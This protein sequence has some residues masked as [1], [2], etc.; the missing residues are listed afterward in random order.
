MAEKK[1]EKPK[2]AKPK[3]KSKPKSREKRPQS[4]RGK[5]ASVLRGTQNSEVATAVREQKMATVLRAYQATGLIKEACKIACMNYA[6]LRQWKEEYPEFRKEVELMQDEVNQGK[7]EAL[8]QALF[9]RAVDG[10]TNP[11][12]N[13]LVT[14]YSDTAAMFILKRLE[15]AYRDTATQV[16]M[17][18][19]LSATTV[20][21]DLKLVE[22]PGWY[23]NDAHDLA[24][25]ALTAHSPGAP[26][27]S[28]VQAPG[29]R[30]AVE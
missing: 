23:G 5:S 17:T 20:N 13:G 11:S 24:A 30:E 8:E 28:E 2:T 18:N 27:A 19:A 6:T 29:V 15:P 22:D 12:A 4:T 16:N 25:E 1:P 7:I 14:N 10:Y 26:L 9:T 3:A 21:G